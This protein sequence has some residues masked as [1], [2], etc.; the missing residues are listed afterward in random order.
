MRGTGAVGYA[1]RIPRA[2]P[3]RFRGRFRCGDVIGGDRIPPSASRRV[4]RARVAGP[5]SQRRAPM[6]PHWVEKMHDRRA[7]FT[8]N[9]GMNAQ[10]SDISTAYD[11]IPSTST[12]APMSRR[13]PGG[14]R[15]SLL[16][17]S[18]WLV[19]F[20]GLCLAAGCDAA[21]ESN[22][23]SKD[24]DCRAGRICASGECVD[25]SDSGPCD[26][27]NGDC[28][29]SGLGDRY[30]SMLSAGTSTPVD[31]PSDRIT[32]LFSLMGRSN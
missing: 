3:A 20:A 5:D 12:K 11:L 1:L 21:D 22:G 19:P 28:Q 2:R 24:T 26:G 10:E 25:E 31:T 27:D 29:S 17:M 8:Y 16:V 32:K 4:R 23:C 9:G 15:R 7:D 30:R 18:L 6:W 14:A 13:G